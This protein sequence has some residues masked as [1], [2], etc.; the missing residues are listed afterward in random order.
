M[1]SANSGIRRTEV[2]ARLLAAIPANYA[3]TSLATA[4]LARLL[5][6]GLGVDAANASVTATLLSFAVF[7]IVALTAFG[8]RSV[9]RIWI[10]MIV[11]ALVLGGALWLSLMAGGRL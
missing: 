9:A 10:G 11:A 6:K 5:W 7:A 2:I 4:C 3:L 1:A 8:M